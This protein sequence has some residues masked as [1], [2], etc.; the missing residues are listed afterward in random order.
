[1]SGALLLLP[2]MIS[3]RR[4]RQLF[5]AACGPITEPLTSRTR[6]LMQQS[7]NYIRVYFSKITVVNLMR[8]SPSYAVSRSA[9][10]LKFGQKR[11]HQCLFM[12]VRCRVTRNSSKWTRN[13]FIL[14]PYCTKDDADV[15]EARHVGQTGSGDQ[16]PRN[17]VHT[18]KRVASI[19]PTCSFA[20]A[21]AMQEGENKQDRNDGKRKTRTKHKGKRKK[22]SKH[23]KT[24]TVIKTNNYRK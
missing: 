24:K 12:T 20:H 1:M 19:T 17:L 2:C 14:N 3:Q 6:P 10:K 11:I 4:Q 22:K 23:W 21:P 16:T 7:L 8:S 15:I 5:Q 13:L 9:S 18:K